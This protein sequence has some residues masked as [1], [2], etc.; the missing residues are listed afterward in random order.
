MPVQRTLT[1]LSVKN[2]KKNKG[3]HLEFVFPVKLSHTNLLNTQMAKAHFLIY[4]SLSYMYMFMYSV[5][6]A[7]LH[8]LPP[9]RNKQLIQ[10]MFLYKTCKHNYTF[11]S[12][13]RKQ[14]NKW[15]QERAFIATNK[16][17]LYSPSSTIATTF[18]SISILETYK[19]DVAPSMWAAF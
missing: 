9:P 17:L 16:S 7:N 13:M 8:N 12:L 10:V 5:W 18:K 2:T 1:L 15:F 19:I 3:F 4:S 6:F 11:F 14:L